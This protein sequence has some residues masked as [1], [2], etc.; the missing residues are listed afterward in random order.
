MAIFDAVDINDDR[1]EFGAIFH[2]D[3]EDPH[4]SSRAIAECLRK[5]RNSTDNRITISP[6]EEVAD[7]FPPSTG[8]SSINKRQANVNTETFTSIGNTFGEFK[9]LRG[10]R[11]MFEKGSG[12]GSNEPRLFCRPG[13]SIH[14][15]AVQNLL[16]RKHE[17]SAS[18]DEEGA[19][20]PNT[21]CCFISHSSVAAREQP[22]WI[23]LRLR[24]SSLPEKRG[25]HP[26]R[27]VE[28]NDLDV[29]LSLPM[30]SPRVSL[31]S[32]TPYTSMLAH[33]C[34]LRPS[35][36]WHV[37]ELRIGAAPA[38]RGKAA[39]LIFRVSSSLGQKFTLLDSTVV[40]NYQLASPLPL[41][42]RRFGFTRMN[43]KRPIWSDIDS[44]SAT[45]LL[46]VIDM[47]VSAMPPS[48][49]GLIGVNLNL[50]L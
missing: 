43:E 45:S 33:P 25:D 41:D 27:K 14:T 13:L 30:L 4:V 26:T 19:M 38:M 8:L 49:G 22:G 48:R 34:L 10:S 20:L 37:E 5:S 46:A 17:T 29:L 21:T 35:A 2:W 11:P 36:S 47:F 7:D 39:M 42:R 44:V 16:I 12:P 18:V 50:G 6:T 31:R 32:F 9:K 3:V 1:A 40:I 24:F 28:E 23:Q 15:K